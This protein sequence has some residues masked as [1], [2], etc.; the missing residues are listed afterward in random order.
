MTTTEQQEVEMS[1]EK[2]ESDDKSF[3]E[4]HASNAVSD[5][6]LVPPRRMSSSR[7][8][9]RE[10]IDLPTEEERQAILKTIM[11]ERT[12]GI[13]ALP[14]AIRN[15]VHREYDRHVVPHIE[16]HWPDSLDG[17][18]C[19]AGQKLRFLACD[20]YA[21]APYTI[22]FCSREKPWP[23][24]IGS[25]LADVFPLP[26]KVLV[27]GAKW[28]VD[29]FGSLSSKARHRRIV[30]I[31]A[32]IA[33]IDHAFDHGMERIA[34][35]D[36]G[37]RIRELLEGTWKP[38]DVDD[39]GPLRLT[40]AL[41]LA[42]EDGLPLVERDAFDLA[43]DRVKDWA[44]SEV[45]GMT[46]VPD[47]TGLSHR[48]AGVEGT[49]DGLFFPV[50]NHAEEMHRKWMYDVSWFVQMMDDWLDFEKDL[51]DVR[52][53]P[54]ITGQW[55]SDHIKNKWA[56]TIYGIE[57]LTR[58]SGVHSDAYVSLVRDTYIFMMH[59]V[60]DAMTHGIAA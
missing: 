28:S 57:S 34:P 7:K 48:L 5:T 46:G 3:V 45:A 43:M 13:D 17:E 58:E 18:A 36:R 15:L 16:R 31:G 44:E 50:F 2:T 23:F 54:V 37:K 4:E 41:Q 52:E 33:T 39:D 21:S 42:M 27:H 12:P 35:K 30:L 55:T 10:P 6:P 60:M 26:R 51:L 40:R 29:L 24:R 32:F 22:L 19:A 25:G 9:V 47:P 8:A 11:G 38:S 14:A 56:D 53:T 59:D 1:F 20:L 49:I